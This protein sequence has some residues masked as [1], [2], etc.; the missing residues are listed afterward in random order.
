MRSNPLPPHLLTLTLVR[1]YITT[2][3]LIP[4]AC[5]PRIIH[6]VRTTPP[7]AV[8]PEDAISFIHACDTTF[9]GTTFQAAKGEESTKT[10]SHLG[11]NHRGGRPG[12]IRVRA[13]KRTVVM[14]DY[15]G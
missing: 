5:T 11:L 3:S 8:L 15:S 12:F 13:D 7:T 9:L 1:K 4:H 10:P 14:P 6:D 2:R